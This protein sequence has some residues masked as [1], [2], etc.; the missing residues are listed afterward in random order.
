[1]LHEVISSTEQQAALKTELGLED[2][3][4]ADQPAS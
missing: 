1:L 3:P 4:A 2:A